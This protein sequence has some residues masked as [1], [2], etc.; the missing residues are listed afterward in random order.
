MKNL[1]D[2]FSRATRHPLYW[3][4]GAAAC[5]SLGAVDGYDG[6]KRINDVATTAPV[7]ASAQAHKAA[8]EKRAAEAHRL[9][10]AGA[11]LHTTLSKVVSQTKDG[12]SIDMNVITSEVMDKATTLRADS[13]RFE[14]ALKSDFTLSEKEV[15]DI[16]E[17]DYKRG[18][19]QLNFTLTFAESGATT[20]VSL[21]QNEADAGADAEDASYFTKPLKF[22]DE[23]RVML[24]LPASGA[25]AAEQVDNLQTCMTE[26]SPQKLPIRWE[27]LAT[28][29][30]EGG[31]GLVGLSL[32]AAFLRRRRD[33][34]I[35]LRGTKLSNVIF[36]DALDRRREQIAAKKAEQ[37]RATQQKDARQALDDLKAMLSPK[38]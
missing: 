8:Y 25:L 31:M 27:R 37:D 26:A 5:V 9:A 7:A 4:L 35:T 33:R 19:L 22:R 2:S 18:D 28:D 15:R 11:E 20:T 17:K 14:S 32:G 16:Y 36:G 23:C 21:A 24:K 29:T 3:T 34:Y 12:V 13:E 6:A 30:A 1:I 38:R 10:Q